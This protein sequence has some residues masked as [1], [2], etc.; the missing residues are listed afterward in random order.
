MYPVPC[1]HLWI[2][3]HDELAPLH[4]LFTVALPV[5]AGQAAAVGAVHASRKAVAVQLEALALLAVARLG[6]AAQGG[7]GGGQVGAVM[8]VCSYI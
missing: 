2:P 8:R 6:G 3:L 7:K 4:H 5:H 1:T